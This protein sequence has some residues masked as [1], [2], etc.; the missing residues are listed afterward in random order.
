MSARLKVAV[1]CVLA[2]SCAASPAGGE[3]ASSTTDAAT[4][5]GVPPTSIGAEEPDAPLRSA[6]SPIRLVFVGDVML[7]RGV[8]PV[9]GGDPSSVFE[10]LRPALAGADLAFANLESPLTDRPHAVGEFAVEA[11]PGA[12]SLL[13]GAGFDIL[14]IANNHAT[15][16]G[17]DTVLDTQAAL[18]TAGLLTAGGGETSAAAREPLI[19]EL[20]GMTVGVV[21]FDNAGGLA[22]TDTTAGVNAWDADAARAIVTELRST[23]DVV[24]VGLHGGVEYLTRPD[25]ALAHIAGLL[26]EWGADVVWGHGAHVTYPVSIS[27]DGEHTSVVAPGLGNALF[28]QRMPRTRV[29]SVLEVLADRSGVLAMRTGRVEIYAGRATFVGWDDPVGDAVALEADWWTPVRAWSPADG[30][31][32]AWGTSPL[33]DRVDE[34]ARSIGDITGTGVID[35]VLASRRP[36]TAEPAHDALP[37]I[38]WFDAQGKTAHLGVYTGAGRLRWGSALMFQ[39]VDAIAVCDGAMALGFTTMREPTT[40]S[41]GAWFWDGFGFRTAAVLPGASTPTCADI[42]ADGHTDPVLTDRAPAHAAGNGP[43]AGAPLGTRND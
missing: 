6:A 14:G 31:T 40:A 2:S 32:R 17:P 16:G 41:G 39:P 33:P 21:A 25:P 37:Q 10:R 29:G 4:A 27:D 38:D 5:T 23:V 3:R 34:V 36:A 20:A 11:D 35:I 19:V 42:D 24:V 22:A 7:G 9:V 28:D 1:V 8:A 15:D 18:S 26:A 43:G 30:T 13:A 12:A